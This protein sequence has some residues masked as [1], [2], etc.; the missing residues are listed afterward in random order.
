MEM[1]LEY[2][3][4]PKDWNPP[5]WLPP[6]KMIFMLPSNAE[7]VEKEAKRKLYVPSESVCAYRNLPQRVKP[8]YSFIGGV[9]GLALSQVVNRGLEAVNIGL[10]G[11]GI[12]FGYTASVA[13][14]SQLPKIHKRSLTITQSDLEEMLEEALKNPL[15]NVMYRKASESCPLQ[16]KIETGEPLSVNHSFSRYQYRKQNNQVVNLEIVISE[17]LEPEAAFEALVYECANAYQLDRFDALHEAAKEGRIGQE[18]YAICF[19]LIELHT[20]LLSETVLSYGIEHLNWQV[21]EPKLIEEFAKQAM[22]HEVGILDVK[23]MIE[24]CILPGDSF[25]HADHYRKAW[26]QLQKKE[27]MN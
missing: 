25:C 5:D 4:L 22:K 2:R 6:G 18:D 23:W 19:E 20:Q 10:L 26:E 14:A 1:S 24:N 13:L 16:L 17:K 27:T 8:L 7:R 9:G 12:L 21:E 3:G 11:I 15:F